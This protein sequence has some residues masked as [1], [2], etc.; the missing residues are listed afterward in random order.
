MR[1]AFCGTQSTGKS[2][3]VKELSK[4][5]FFEDYKI[6]TERSGYLSSL[7]IPLNEN[8]TYKGQLIFTAERA[9][10]L[11]QPNFI[12][13]RS[14]ID[15]V[16]FAFESPLMTEE[17]KYLILSV[18]LPLIDLYD[19]IFYTPMEIPLEDNGIRD[20]NPDFREKID[21]WVKF[22]AEQ[23]YVDPTKKFII[24]GTLIN[25][26]KTIKNILNIKE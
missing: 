11:M 6:F 9:S 22:F 14:V 25:R 7:G 16:S 4:L 24:E 19:Y 18:N 20:T 26:I 2:T 23:E 10:E 15:V 1:L 21:A 12:S 8:S 3:L 17:E 13:D 5:P